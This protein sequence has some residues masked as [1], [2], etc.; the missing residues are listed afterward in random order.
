[1][2]FQTMEYY[3]MLQNHEKTW[4]K[5]KC[6]LLSEKKDSLKRLNTAKYEMLHTVDSDYLRFWERQSHED[7]RKICGWTSLTI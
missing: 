4:K 1:M 5:P 7:S 6:I 2:V 3:S